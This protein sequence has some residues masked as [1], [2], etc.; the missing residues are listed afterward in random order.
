MPY[1]INKYNGS[2]ITVVAD[3]TV[4]QTTSLKLVG[5]NYA[6]YG[7]IQ[8]EN[9]LYLLENFASPSPG[10]SNPIPGQ[11]WF[12]TAKNK[13]NFYDKNLQWRTAGGSSAQ[14]TA[15]TGLVTG[16][17]WFDTGNNQLYVWNADPSPGQFVLVGPEGVPGSGITQMLSESVVDQTAQS[18]SI[19]KAV[20]NDQVAFIIS[21]DATFTLDNDVNAITG[22]S[23]VQQGVTLAYTNNEAEPGQTQNN[24]R[25]WGT[26]SN[27]ELFGGLEPA[28][29]IL[30]ASP[31]FNAQVHFTNDGFTVGSP[32]V[33]EASIIGGTPNI[34]NTVSNEIRFNTTV[35]SVLVTPLR[36][37]GKTLQPGSSDISVGT[38]SN[39]F[40]V[41]YANNFNGI[42]S[43]SDTVLLL[44]VLPAD[45]D[46]SKEHTLS[47]P[48][49]RHCMLT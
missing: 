11:L 1:T 15:P 36:L 25:F 30:S 48:Q 19:I 37:I 5:K 35:S 13:L 41:M 9:F 32:Y 20:V 18:H 4:D 28:D 16:D 34:S 12:D 31:T 49:L 17:F 29:Y 27:S 26:A 43:Q 40:N 33:L 39:P 8:N 21:T 7:E 45:Q 14:A 2:P 38:I 10:P 47:V 3:G 44:M 46:L 6:G 23:T 42:A 24:F 22:F